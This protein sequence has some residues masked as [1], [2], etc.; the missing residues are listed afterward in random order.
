MAVG[1]YTIE[2]ST[3]GVTWT[4]FSDVQSI[5][6]RIGRQAFID[7]FQPSSMTFLMR[8][9]TG[10][11]SPIA[12]LVTGTRVRLKRTGIARNLW[13]GLIAN[14]I[15]EW[16]P[17]YNT[18]TNRGEMDYVTVQCEGAFAA[19]GRL[20]G[21]NNTIVSTNAAFALGEAAAESGLPI[22]TT[23]SSST[24][25]T[26]D[27]STVNGSW[28]DWVNK[29]AVTLSATIKDGGGQLGVYTKDFVGSLPVSFSDT[30]NNATNQVYEAIQL[31]SQVENYFTEVL[32][33]TESFG[34][35][36]AAV[37]AGPYRT[38]KL[39]TFNGSL[40]QATDLANYYLALYQTP[41]VTISQVTC[42][43]EAQ[44]TWALDLGYEW[45]DILGYRTNL[46]FRGTTY[47]MS[48]LGSSF[49][50]TPSG[51]TFTYD[52]ASAAFLPFFILNDPNYGILGTN[53]LSW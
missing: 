52:L 16:G 17:T 26:I 4:M 31:S 9:P 10:Y 37:G 6:A 1:N 46:T 18:T 27:T 13:S 48:I 15:V 11:N 43:S 8:Y 34:Q 28:A 24:A 45:Y 19:W 42:R 38:L 14:V 39:S 20:Q 32:I 36:R 47:Y 35:A 41:Q 22:G 2:Y 51:S 53:R 40:S 30:T 49:Q 50:A 21:N 23:Y 25:P 12:A 33:D 29:F 5:Q 3:D 7:T 44:N